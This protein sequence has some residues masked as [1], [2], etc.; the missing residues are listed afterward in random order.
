S[1]PGMIVDFRGN[2]GG[3]FDH[4]EFLGR[5]LPKG[6]SLPT[7]RGYK[8]SGEHPYGGPLVVTVCA[9]VRSAGEAGSGIF[10]EDGRG[11][12]IGESPTAGMSSSKETI[13]LPSKLFALYV[14]VDS[15]MNR[16]NKGK[17]IQGTGG[18]PP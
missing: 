1:V 3:G 9:G 6:A 17:G 16:F 8:S 2:G 13:E 7:G 4:D 5:F 15:N 12:M 18:G 11:W 10:K 14:S